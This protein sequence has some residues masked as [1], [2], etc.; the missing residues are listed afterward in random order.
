MIGF[1]NL[2]ERDKDWD[3]FRSAPE[4]KTLF[5]KPQYTFEDLVSNVDNSVLAPAA[6]SQI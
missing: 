3:A 1:T 5:A 2:A 6:Y 4:T